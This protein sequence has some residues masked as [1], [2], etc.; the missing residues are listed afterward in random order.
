MAPTNPTS[1]PISLE[2]PQTASSSSVSRRTST[3]SETHPYI[4]LTTLRQSL[5]RKKNRKLR[6]MWQLNPEVRVKLF[7]ARD[8]L[9]ADG[10]VR[11]PLVP[12]E[13]VAANLRAKRARTTP[14]KDGGV[15]QGAA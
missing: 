14:P 5:V 8:F 6:W 12:S 11:P 7:Y 3:C 2:M 10:E 13:I 1:S 15:T 9:S 4:E